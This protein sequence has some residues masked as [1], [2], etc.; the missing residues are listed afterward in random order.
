MG[1][2]KKEE[3]RSKKHEN[4]SPGDVSVRD[5]ATV[6]HHLRSPMLSRRNKATRG[7][8]SCLSRSPRVASH[9]ASRDLTRCTHRPI[10][11]SRAV[12]GGGQEREFSPSLPVRPGRAVR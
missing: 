10:P 11:I 2:R 3:R 4:N 9:V 5:S 1:R 6:L 8:S 12:A 7:T